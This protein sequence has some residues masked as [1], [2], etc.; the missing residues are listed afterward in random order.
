MRRQQ[1]AR[2]GSGNAAG[3]AADAAAGNGEHKP[4]GV[5]AVASGDGLGEILRSLGV[6]VVVT[7][8]QTMNP[9]TQDF[10]EAA[11]KI[12]ADAILF[13]PNNKN[14]IMAAQAATTALE[15]PAAVV[16]TKNVPA[17]F[18]AM[19]AFDPGESDLDC[20]VEAMMESASEVRY[21]EITTAIKNSK[22][23]I[24]GAIKKGEVIGIVGNKEIEAKGKTVEE[25]ALALLP[26]LGA[27]ECE[28]CTLLAGEEYDDEA[29]DALVEKI[30]K[31]W[32]ELE[33]DPQRGGQPLYPL[34]LAVE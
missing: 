3:I 5:V 30:E 27:G 19:L 28:T 12:S 20:L 25:V 2:P 15:V 21:G 13:L 31:A 9:S 32:P 22:G 16:P 23:A 24:V 14:I 33:V 26:L 17:S 7:G 4:V 10:V 34:L 29:L 1:Q 18:S 11:G 6:D 8:G